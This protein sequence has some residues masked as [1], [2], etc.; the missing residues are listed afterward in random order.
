MDNCS[1]VTIVMM[2]QY[3]FKEGIQQ[4]RPK[5]EELRSRHI[6]IICEHH[7]NVSCP[8]SSGKE[9]HQVFSGQLSAVHENWLSCHVRWET[10]NATEEKG[11]C[12]LSFGSVYIIYSREK[13]LSCFLIDMGSQANIYQVGQL[14][15]WILLL[16]KRRFKFSTLIHMC[17]I[18]A[19]KEQT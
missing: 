14:L 12:S 9:H 18:N 16:K 8:L 1:H 5:I 15:C 13:F 3:H 10:I 7:V 4:T 19:E 2:R 6:K 11:L 17:V